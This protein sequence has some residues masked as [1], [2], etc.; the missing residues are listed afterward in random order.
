MQPIFFTSNPD[1]ADESDVLRQCAEIVEKLDLAKQ[2][3]KTLQGEINDALIAK[4]KALDEAEVK[5]LAIIKWES[6]LT[7]TIESDRSR[8]GQRLSDRIST[9][10][11]RYDEVLAI[12]EERVMTLGSAVSQHLKAMTDEQ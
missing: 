3:I 12:I 11:E 10:G 7:A 4:Y 2:A 8:V 6:V 9:L 1:F 5:K